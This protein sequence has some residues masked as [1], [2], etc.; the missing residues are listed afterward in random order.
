[1][2]AT[3]AWATLFGTEF[4]GHNYPKPNVIYAANPDKSPIQE[5]SHRPF[6]T[7]IPL[8]KRL[9]V[10]VIIDYEVGQEGQLASTIVTGSGVVLVSWEHEAITKQ[11]LPSIAAAQQI[12]NLPHQWDEARYDLVLRFDRSAP[13]APWDFSQLCPCLLSG[14]S[15]TLMQ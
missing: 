10:P 14:D 3:G 8:S 2:A 13:G 4:G 7:V 6:Q 5:P 11:L 9:G 1:L 12:K 15:A